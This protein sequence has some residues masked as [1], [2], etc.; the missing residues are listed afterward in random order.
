[1]VAGL[2]FWGVFLH[3]FVFILFCTA[4][5]DFYPTNV[6]LTANL[7]LTERQVKNPAAVLS[8]TDFPDFST[9]LQ[10]LDKGWTSEGTGTAAA[11]DRDDNFW[12]GS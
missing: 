3:F 8:L 6:C 1:M 12:P 2:L 9:F 10:V 7:M 5:C 11:A 4:I